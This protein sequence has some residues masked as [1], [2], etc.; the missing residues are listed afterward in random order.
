MV[1]GAPMTAC[2]GTSAPCTTCPMI[3]PRVSGMYSVGRVVVDHFDGYKV[4][5]VR[6]PGEYQVSHRR[7]TA[8]DRLLL[9]VKLAIPR[10]YLAVDIEFFCRR[11]IRP[12]VAEQCKAEKCQLA[13]I[14]HQ[15]KSSINLD[16]QQQTH[17]STH[18][19]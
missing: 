2:V 19:S 15:S 13:A 9:V 6:G 17:L 7:E 1:L 8:G 10:M 3:Y 5:H 14:F 12:S 11:R 4:L 16:L 18:I